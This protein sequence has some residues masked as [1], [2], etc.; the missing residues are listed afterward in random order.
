M[1][2][3]LV[4]AVLLGLVAVFVA[5]TA[6]RRH[7]ELL[8][9]CGQ[10]GT[11]RVLLDEELEDVHLNEKQRG[12]ERSGAVDY[13]VWWCG[14]CEDGI[15]IRN[16]LFTV[17]S[18][19]CHGCGGDVEERV[20]ALVPATLTRGGEFRVDLTCARCGHTQEFSRYTPKTAPASSPVGLR[21]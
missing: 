7:R 21:S 2:L 12:E 11:A 13:H 8:E 19:R 18:A 5:E 10:C 20:Q 9:N 15:V 14:T 6:S 4:V 17:R 1:I 3:I 16:V